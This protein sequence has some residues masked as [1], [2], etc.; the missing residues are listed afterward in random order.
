MGEPAGDYHRGEMDIHEQ[1]STYAAFL[2]LSKWGSLVLAAGVLFFTLL[3]CTNTGFLGS[4]VS[5]F[6]VLVLG[7]LLLRAKPQAAGH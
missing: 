7:F 5:A 3:F 2:T 4:A 6:V 1:A